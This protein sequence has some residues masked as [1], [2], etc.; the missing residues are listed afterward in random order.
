MFLNSYSQICE[1][2]IDISKWFSGAGFGIEIMESASHYALW[3]AIR[4][5]RPPNNNP[6]KANAFSMQPRPAHV[7]QKLAPQPCKANSNSQDC[8]IRHDLLYCFI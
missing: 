1:H 7:I 8:H 6:M 3:Y 2:N 5:Y 4:V